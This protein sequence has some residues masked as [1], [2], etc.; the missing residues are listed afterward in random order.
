M[1]PISQTVRR[2]VENAVGTDTGLEDVETSG[3][4][5]AGYAQ[6]GCQERRLL[7]TAISAAERRE[8]IA[9]CALFKLTGKLIEE[10][11][12]LSAAVMI[13]GNS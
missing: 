7:P 10:E 3:Y 6:G 12:Q 8:G 1:P 13:G 2:P 11:Q 9:Q 4:Y 5:F